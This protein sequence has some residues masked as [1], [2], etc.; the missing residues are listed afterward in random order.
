MP[1][2]IT[3]HLRDKP[4]ALTLQSDYQRYFQLKLSAGFGNAIGY[5]GTVHD[6]TKYVHK[7]RFNL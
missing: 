7:Y 3:V 1:K 6:P 4:S 5:Y 2:W